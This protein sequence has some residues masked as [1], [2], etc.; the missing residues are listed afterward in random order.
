MD[1]LASENYLGFACIM[2]WFYQN[3]D[4]AI[5][6]PQEVVQLPPVEMQPQWS[7]ICNSYWLKI[8]R[9][10]TSGNAPELSLRVAK[11]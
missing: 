8:R 2:P 4:K 3:Y 7:K 10:K 11:K 9:L 5:K 1:G 6:E